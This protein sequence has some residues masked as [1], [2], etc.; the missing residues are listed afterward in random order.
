MSHVEKCK[1][2]YKDL[3]ILEST[4]SS[5]VHPTYGK[6]IRK[7]K[8]TYKWYGKHMGDYPLPIG[9]KKEDLGKCDVCFGFEDD[10]LYEIGIVKRGE[11]YVPLYDFW[12][13]NGSGEG[14]PLLDILGKDGG[15]LAQT[16]SVNII[17]STCEEKG[18]N[19]EE[20][21]VDGD[22]NVILEVEL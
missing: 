15:K 22:G 16:Y 8:N 10:S 13:I 9:F 12:S 11:E 3:D 19:V 5:L 21:Y 14:G 18:Y 17:L 2:V 20:H 7:E 1:G 6:L 4:L